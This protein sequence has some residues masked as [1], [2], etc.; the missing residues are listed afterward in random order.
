MLDLSIIILN[1]NTKDLILECISSIRQQYKDQFDNE[2]FEIIVVDNNSTDESLSFLRKF[3]FNGFNLIETKENLGFSNGCNLGA[4]NAKGEYLLFL[5]SDTQIK[6]QGFLKMFNFLKDK[7]KIG[8]LGGKLKNADGSS[9][10]SG[11]KFYNIPNL[12][13]MLLGM[14]KFASLRQSPNKIQKIDWVSGACLM[15]KKSVFE[16]IG[17]FEKNIF[18]YM[19]DMELCFKAKKRGLDTYFYP[20]IMLYHKEL[21]SSNRSFAILNIY[22]GII[23]FYKKHM[24][25]WQFFLAK[26]LLYLKSIMLFGFGK[27]TGNNYLIQT[28]G[29]TLKIF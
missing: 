5:N 16:K 28:Y 12:L 6:D 29:E 18:M 1:Y 7:E 9:Q 19:E 21:G 8:I 17:G 15:V 3:R 13:L 10:L 14:E 26:T 23:L 4:K 27:L 24:P 25:K 2:K 22:K 11:G 20:E